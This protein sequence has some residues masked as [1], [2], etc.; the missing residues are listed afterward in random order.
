VYIPQEKASFAFG[1]VNLCFWVFALFPQIIINYRRKKCDS[2]SGLFL[3]IWVC[4]DV[5]NLLGCLWTQQLPTQLMTA[6]YFVFLDGTSLSQWLYYEKLRPYFTAKRSIQLDPLLDRSSSSGSA[7]VNATA[8]QDTVVPG[9]DALAQRGSEDNVRLL[10]APLLLLS[11]M[12]FSSSLSPSLPS[13]NAAGRHLLSLT[14]QKICN[15]SAAIPHGQ[16]ILGSILAWISGMCYFASRIPQAVKNYRRK[17]IEGL[18]MFLFISSLMANIS[19]GISVILRIP[20][21]DNKFFESTFP[22]LLGSLGT[23]V[24]DV[25]IL[26]Q[27]NLYKGDNSYWSFVFG[28]VFEKAKPGPV[29]QV[30]IFGRVPNDDVPDSHGYRT[31]AEDQA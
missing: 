26:V 11:L 22:Y 28:N 29:P 27:A 20:A 8:D 31:F 9:S 3:A 14:E 19:Y 21:I 7:S 16:R 23:L 5:S 4:G 1:L 12:A 25:T 24:W 2:L 10:A 17:N 30:D 13:T 6:V 18:S 15:A